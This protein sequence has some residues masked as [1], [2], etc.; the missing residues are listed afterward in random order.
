MKKWI[1]SLLC[2]ALLLCTL[3]MAA[4]AQGEEEFDM[5]YYSRFQGKKVSINVYN[6]GEYI[7]NGEDESLDVNKAF[8]ELTGITVNYTTFDSN[9]ALYAKMKSGGTNYDVII[10]SDYMIARMITEDMVEPLDFANIPKYENIMEKFRT[11]HYDPG[12][13][14]SVPYTWGTVGIIYNTTMVDREIDSWDV[15]WDPSYAGDILMFSNPRDAF[16][17]S[18]KRLG[19]SLNTEDPEEL[20]QA[21]EELK[22]QKPVVQAYVMDQVFDKMGGGEAALAPYYAGDAVTMIDSNPDLDFAV[23]KEGT[24]VFVDAVCIPKGS[25]NK[26][27]AEMYI[28]FLCEATVAAEN[29][30]Y[31]GYSSPNQAAFELLDPEIQESAIIY[32]PDDV[33]AKSEEFLNLTDETNRLIESLWTEVLSDDSGFADWVMPVLLA[34]GVLLAVLRIYLRYQKRKRDGFIP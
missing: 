32:P 22:K 34:G 3:P 14:Y 13:V 4:F 6:W 31:I 7:A 25:E 30:S 5:D 18:L 10:P 33:I 19:F 28:N 15:L 26:E 27:A 21:A 2:T 24:N 9:E 17:I 11:S 1:A 12:N 29:I 16:G 23:P 8:E 20:A